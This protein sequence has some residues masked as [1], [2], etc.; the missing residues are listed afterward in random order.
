MIRPASQRFLS[1]VVL[2]AA[3]SCAPSRAPVG[4]GRSGCD[5]PPGAASG[6]ASAAPSPSTGAVAQPPTVGAVESGQYRNLFVEAG[7]PAQEVQVKLEGAFQQLFHGDPKEQAVMFS[8]PA[9]QQGP[10]AYI[11][12]INNNDVRSE[13]MSY[14]MMIAV[15]MDRK[16]E[17]DALWNWAKTHMYHADPKHPAY[18][19]FSWQ[20]RADGTAIDEMPAAD[21]EEYFAT[22]LFFASHRWGDGKGIYAYGSEARQLLHHMKNR[23]PIVGR[24]N[25][26]RETT[27]VSLF[28]P[29]HKMVR[30]TPDSGNFAK[31]G[32]FS[33]PSYH[34]PAFYELWARWANE[35]DRQFWADAARVSRDYF[36]KV[37]HPRTGLT[38]DY[39]SFEGTPKAA[40]WDN[41]TVHF[42]FDAFRTAMNWS[43][44]WAWWAK[45]P[46]QRELS[47][48][49][50]GFFAGLGPEYL[51]N[52]TL[53][54][55]P[56]TT[57]GSLGLVATNGVAALS[58][59]RPEAT[60][61][62]EALYQ[63]EP[64]TGKYRYYDGMLYLLGM[65]HVSG[66][67][68]VYEPA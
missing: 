40:S 51:A 50:L 20:L 17:F 64:P 13:G 44:D 28:N 5:G 19:Y 37:A 41:G 43:V 32:D 1:Q 49:L 6:D 33:D 35:G 23:Q 8:A 54:G 7:K 14:G 2:V 53:E 27:G 42:R 66:K 58:A 22:A 25:G 48:R 62:V 26:T 55:K 16:Q 12:D 30:F 38:P 10:Q 56:L 45:D 39:A 47:D 63:K 18:G 60:R 34:L 21:G 36:V 15:E 46:R 59:T 24:I 3:V 52:Y 4:P 57:Y 61:F 31:N 68:R 11:M 29:E 9:N 65:L 67:F